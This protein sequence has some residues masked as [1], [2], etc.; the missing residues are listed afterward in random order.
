MASL[1]PNVSPALTPSTPAV[2][3][4][5]RFAERC[6][7]AGIRQALALATCGSLGP[8]QAGLGPDIGPISH[9]P[10]RPQAPVSPAW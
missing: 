8:G 3:T 10:G 7:G 9:Y 4:S 1:L 5:T 6:P 2:P